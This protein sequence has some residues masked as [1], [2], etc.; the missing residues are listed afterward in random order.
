MLKS[1][2]IT[3]EMNMNELISLGEI[4]LEEFLKPLEISQE[5]LARDIDVPK[6]RISRI[7]SGKCSITEDT[8][9]RLGEFFGN[10]PQFWLNLQNEYGLRKVKLSTWPQIK[11]RIRKHVI[12]E[13]KK[14]EN[15]L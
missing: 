8:A 10:T 2:I 1:L 12:G 7:V 13:L 9:L 14:V 11:P 4:L 5:Q 3:D 6:S 15:I